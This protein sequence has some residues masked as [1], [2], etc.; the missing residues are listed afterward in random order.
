M[1][2]C[3]LPYI[4]DDLD[5]EFLRSVQGSKN[6]SSYPQTAVCVCAFGVTAIR[7]ACF[8]L[9][10][11]Q[12]RSFYKYTRV[13]HLGHCRLSSANAYYVFQGDKRMEGIHYHAKVLHDFAI[14]CQFRNVRSAVLK[15]SS[16]YCKTLHN[17]IL[18]L[19]CIRPKGIAKRVCQPVLFFSPF[20]FLNKWLQTILA[21][22]S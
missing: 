16:W 15:M 21:F 5:Q 20:V 8:S 12:L 19:G 11:W 3:Q 7:K 2:A 18:F 14:P 22:F 13:E 4:L 1:C 10:F 6:W 9:F 17:S